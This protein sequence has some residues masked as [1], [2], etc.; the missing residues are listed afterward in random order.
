MLRVCQGQ[1]PM[2]RAVEQ[3]TRET[4]HE[5]SVSKMGAALEDPDAENAEVSSGEED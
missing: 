4:E 1:S 5:L 3:R 2:F